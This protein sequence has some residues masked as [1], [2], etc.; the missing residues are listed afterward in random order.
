MKKVLCITM[1]FFTVTVSLKAQ[2]VSAAAVAE[3]IANK[4]KD[5]LN[6]NNAQ[7]NQIFAVNV[8]IN[9]RKSDVRQQYT[10]TDSIR[11]H[12]QRIENRRDSMYHN[13]LAEPKYLLY[14]Q[15]KRFL[16]TAN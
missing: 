15:K 4:M 12:I 6:L 1:L 9:N 7:R 16:V 14:K 13:I 2:T 3:R 10:N 8:L 11:Y 5:S